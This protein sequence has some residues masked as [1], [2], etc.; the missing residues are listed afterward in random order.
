MLLAVS[1]RRKTQHRIRTGIYFSC[2]K[3]PTS[4]PAGLVTTY[5]V[6]ARTAWPRYI[7]VLYTHLCSRERTPWPGRVRGVKIPCREAAHFSTH[8]V[9]DLP[10][11]FITCTFPP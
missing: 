1:Q 3:A 4:R 7:G 2:C 9:L 10:C 8:P 11:T 6:L 5:P